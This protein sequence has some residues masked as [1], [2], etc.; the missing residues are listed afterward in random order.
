MTNLSISNILVN[1]RG[2]KSGILLNGKERHFVTFDES[3]RCLFPPSN[4]DK[5][6]SAQRMTINFELSAEISDWFTQFDTWA[7]EYLQQNS[8]RL[9]GQLLT[10][11]QVEY[12]Y[13]S[14]VKEGKG[15]NFKI[16]M[17]NSP[18]PCRFLES[19]C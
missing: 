12:Q 8:E 15:C 4:F 5:D 3:V 18:R 10:A 6:E 1:G 2:N 17:P 11:D 7:K 16:N 19:R 13:I 14:C 9:F